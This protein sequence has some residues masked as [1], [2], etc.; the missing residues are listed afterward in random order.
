MLLSDSFGTAFTGTNANAILKGKDE[1][2]AIT[3][4][5]LSPGTACLHDGIDR[6][7][8]KIFINSDL[9]LNLAHQM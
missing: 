3:R 2:F 1:Y 4:P 7:F 8:H 5:P 9:Q 6:Q